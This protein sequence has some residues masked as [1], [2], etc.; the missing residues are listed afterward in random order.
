MATSFASVGVAII[1]VD[2]LPYNTVIN[3]EVY[4]ADLPDV[5][6]MYDY[7]NMEPPFSIFYEEGETLLSS[8]EWKEI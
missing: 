1:M 4:F 8:K 7:L 5:E 6:D 2:L 3:G